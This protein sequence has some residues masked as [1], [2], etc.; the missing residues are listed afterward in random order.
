[1]GAEYGCPANYPHAFLN[2]PSTPTLLILLPVLKILL[3]S[4]LIDVT[5]I[6]SLLIAGVR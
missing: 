1:M 6:H 4:T 5:C 3:A 2:H